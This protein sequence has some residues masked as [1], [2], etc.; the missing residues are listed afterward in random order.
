M[1]GADRLTVLW[2]G[3]QSPGHGKE[4]LPMGVIKG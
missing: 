3:Y 4:D 2:G 1:R